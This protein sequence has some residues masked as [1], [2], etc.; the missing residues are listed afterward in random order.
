MAG[1]LR[2]HDFAAL[3]LA[4]SVS[5][6]GTQL[7]AV[8]TAVLAM[9][10]SGGSALVFTVVLASSIVPVILFSWA[11]GVLV[12]RWDKRTVMIVAD[13]ARGLLMLILVVIRVP[14]Q[15][16]AAVA[17]AVGSFTAFFDPALLGLVPRTV[18]DK[19]LLPANSL[20]QS[21]SSLLNIA[22]LGIAGVVI[23][24]LGPR[25]A[26]LV[27]AVSYF[28]SAAAIL[29]VRVRT[30]ADQAGAGG[31]WAELKD[32]VRYHIENRPVLGLLILIVGLT[33]GIGIY[34]AMSMM[35]VERL[36]GR[37]ESDW[38]YLMAVASLATAL[39]GI[40]LGRY[41]DRFNR[42]TLLSGSYI[43]MTLVSVGFAFNR[44]FP[45][46]LVL[47][48]LEGALNG[49]QFIVM[50]TWVQQVVA[51]DRLGR[52][53]SVRFTL[54]NVSIL[55]STVLSGYL[56]DRF[57]VDRMLLVAG[58]IFLLWGLMAIGM[59]SLRDSSRELSRGDID[60]SPANDVQAQLG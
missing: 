21:T 20:T 33:L 5:I 4:Q 17:L 39:T 58:G 10:L 6:L 19:E 60:G 8:A 24:T 49:V 12:D 51:K 14:W 31:F 7:T 13:V 44:V 30:G 48:A 56:A 28:I 32:G 42:L 41:G 18:P 53:F 16:L 47:A 26:F 35:A 46:A 36:L 9:Q 11:A 29:T 23:A 3:W 43:L 45:L 27:D 55:L 1:V 50:T 52:V 59:K 40:W 38:G 37:P 25:P 54:G 57:G 15:G 34:N 22:G 2:H